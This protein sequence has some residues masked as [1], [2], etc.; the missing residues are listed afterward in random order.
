MYLQE[1]DGLGPARRNDQSVLQISCERQHEDD[2]ELDATQGEELPCFLA[3]VDW[4]HGI[5]KSTQSGSRC[6]HLRPTPAPN[7]LGSTLC[8]VSSSSRSFDGLESWPVKLKS[9]WCG[10]IGGS[11][12]ATSGRAKGCVGTKREQECS[13][14]AESISHH[15]IALLFCLPCPNTPAWSARGLYVLFSRSYCRCCGFHYVLFFY[16]LYG[17]SIQ[18]SP[19]ILR[20]TP[21]Q[22]PPPQVY[23]QVRTTPA[24]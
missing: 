14:Q 22:S 2:E 4:E 12:V 20:D 13:D 6:F 8:S 15:S 10:A 19:Q 3:T 24:V 1:G 7:F 18:T 23:Q 21:Y 16:S 17:V 11:K 5:T 9:S